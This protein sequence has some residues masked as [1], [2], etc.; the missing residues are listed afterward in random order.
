MKQVSIF[1]TIPEDANLT[2]VTA[3]SSV[4]GR[5]FTLHA[6]AAN[7][8]WFHE[9]IPTFFNSKEIG[10]R[11]YE[12]DL[13]H[14]VAK[15][16]PTLVDNLSVIWVFTFHMFEHKKAHRLA[17]ELTAYPN[18]PRLTLELDAGEIYSQY[19]AHSSE[20]Q[21]QVSEI[22]SNLQAYASRF[23]TLPR[24]SHFKLGR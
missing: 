24:L 23:Q 14:M 7:K 17:N 8:Q 13:L 15:T 19:D 21:E 20:G 1:A 9:F 2:T 6:F 3:G 10:L 16:F 5:C 18:L 22:E 4:D 12:L 11:V